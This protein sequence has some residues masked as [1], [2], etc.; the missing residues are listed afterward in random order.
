MFDANGQDQAQ[1][2]QAHMQTLGKAH[3]Q[4]LLLSKMATK[5]VL[6]IYGFFSRPKTMRETRRTRLKMFRGE[7]REFGAIW[8]TRAP[9]LVN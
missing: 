6:D 1:D 4:G 3:L 5:I 9:E 2:N 8:S 7:L